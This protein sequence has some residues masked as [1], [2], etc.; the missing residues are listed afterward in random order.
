MATPL[1]QRPYAANGPRVS[2]LDFGDILVTNTT[3]EHAN[4]RS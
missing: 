3:Q 2:I 1:P 4:P